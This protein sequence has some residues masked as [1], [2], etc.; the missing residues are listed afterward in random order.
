MDDS[1]KAFFAGQGGVVVVVMTLI[2]SFIISGY[3]SLSDRCSP[4][5]PSNR[6]HLI[7]L[8]LMEAILWSGIT[9]HL[10][11]ID[12]VRNIKVGHRFHNQDE[13]NP[14]ILPLFEDL[15]HYM[16]D[17]A[18]FNSSMA[19]FFIFHILF[20][21]N[22]RY[23]YHMLYGIL[24]ASLCTAV[25]ITIVNVMNSHEEI[26]GDFLGGHRTFTITTIA[27]CMWICCVWYSVETHLVVRHCHRYTFNSCIFL[28]LCIAYFDVWNI[29]SKCKCTF[30]KPFIKNAQC[31]K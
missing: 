18:V 10:F 27:T 29:I 14:H 13:W 12:Q 9:V 25:P 22:D 23:S 31:S 11:H 24:L 26:E 28:V 6:G 15:Q 7:T 5:N 30:S 21:F 8:T 19:V 1:I 3:M 20:F 17:V 16:M 4:D 2:I